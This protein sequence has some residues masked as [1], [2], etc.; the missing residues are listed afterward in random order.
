[1]G[2]MGDTTGSA[3]DS[4]LGSGSI[5]TGGDSMSYRFPML[6]NLE[7]IAPM[8]RLHTALGPNTLEGNWMDAMYVPA[9]LNPDAFPT[10]HGKGC[11]CK[12]PKKGKDIECK[13]KE[14]KTKQKDHY[15]WLKDTPIPG[16]DKYK[17]EPADITYRSGNYFEP[18][19]KGGIVAPADVMPPHRYPNQALADRIFPLPASAR[20]DRLPVRY[21]RYIDQVQARSEEC[22]TVSKH[23]T[24]KCAPGDKVVAAI[25]NTRVDAKVLKTFVGEAILIEFSPAEAKGV[26]DTA[27]CA[28]DSACTVF[29]LCK[30]EGKPCTQMKDVDSH[31][32]AG[33]LVRKHVCP[34]GSK[35]CGTIQQ[36][37]MSNMLEK[38]GK[39]CKA[40]PKSIKKPPAR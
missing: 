9:Y 33:R 19:P 36:T 12:M 31:N 20:E 14:S 32:W 3:Q 29:R 22:D 10:V 2:M 25:G 11:K 38:D 24:H 21:A 23:C 17:L 37:I 8:D 16:T 1:M 39:A 28:V 40:A 4:S 18:I 15:T 7:P 26:K 6:D 34:K 27:K 35:V 5:W 13:C 30:P